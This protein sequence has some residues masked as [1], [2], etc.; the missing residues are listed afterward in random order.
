MNTNGASSNAMRRNRFQHRDKKI[1]PIVAVAPTV[2]SVADLMEVQA[3]KSL[4]VPSPTFLPLSWFRQTQSLYQ[5][6]WTTCNGAGRARKGLRLD[7]GDHVERIG[8]PVRMSTLGPTTGSEFFLRVAGFKNGRKLDQVRAPP[9][10]ARLKDHEIVVL[11]YW[12]NPGAS[13]PLDE[14]GMMATGHRLRPAYQACLVVRR[15]EPPSVRHAVWTQRSIGSFFRLRHEKNIT[16]SSTKAVA[17]TLV[18]QPSLPDL[19]PSRPVAAAGTGGDLPYTP[20]AKRTSNSW[21]TWSVRL[22]TPKRLLECRPDYPRIFAA[23]SPTTSPSPVRRVV[24][25]GSSRSS[26]ATCRSHTSQFEEA[27]GS[28]QITPGPGHVVP[29]GLHRNV[30]EGFEARSHIQDWVQDRHSSRSVLKHSTIGPCEYDIL[31]PRMP[32]NT[33]HRHSCEYSDRLLALGSAAFTV[34]YP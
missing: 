4:A 21:N 19:V 17:I 18:R 13:S 34:V 24:A 9:D 5:Q 1:W 6:L 14:G 12:I 8:D 25:T 15:L 20:A 32:L 28:S 30:F 2:L 31:C 26:T 27:A 16:V 11:P 7:C 29:A 33:T 3:A 22:S 23:T 10:G